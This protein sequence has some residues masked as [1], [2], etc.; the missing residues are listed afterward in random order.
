M[1]R[2]VCVLE[3]KEHIEREI[4]REREGE[5]DCDWNVK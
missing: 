1:V 5:R 3:V 2:L 4:E